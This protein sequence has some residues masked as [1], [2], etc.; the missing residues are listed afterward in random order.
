MSKVVDSVNPINITQ[1]QLLGQ[2]VLLA[3][4]RQGQACLDDLISVA[5][6]FGLDAS[7]IVRA[8]AGESGM[9]TTAAA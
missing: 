7:A 3:L 4:T 9:L 1:R 6:L 8:I 2:R 5:E